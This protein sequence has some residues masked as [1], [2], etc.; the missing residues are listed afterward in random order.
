MDK[1]PLTRSEYRRRQA[2]KQKDEPQTNRA[3]EKLTR[4]ESLRLT[5]AQLEAERTAQLKHRLN[6]TIIGLVVAFVIV[7]LFLFFVG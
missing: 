4:E 5:K 3:S 7:Y 1:E 6:L 2:Q